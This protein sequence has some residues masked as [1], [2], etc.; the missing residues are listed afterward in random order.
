MA[1]WPKGI[2]PSGKG[3]RITVYHRGEI[4]YDKTHE[5][6]PNS[7]TDLAAAVRFREDL[8]QKLRLGLSIGPDDKHAKYRIFR[9]VAQGYL[10]SRSVD[11]CTAENYLRWLNR[12]W[13]PVFGH[14]AIEEI[15]RQE[16]EDRLAQIR[17]ATPTKRNI[18]SPLAGVFSYAGIHPNPAAG[19][20]LE[21]QT[22][23]RVERYTPAERDAVL[24]KLEGQ[25]KVYFAL[26]FG[27]GIRPGEALALQWTD[28]NGTALDIT[29]QRTRSLLKNYTKTKADRIVYVPEWV[30]DILN[31]HST[32]LAGGFLF[33]TVHGEP[34]LRASEFNKAWR[35]AHSKA[36][37]GAHPVKCRRPYVCR[38]TRASE[39]LSRGTPPAAA[40]AQLGHS[41][42]M[43]LEIYARFVEEFAKGDF[44]MYESAKPNNK[45]NKI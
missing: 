22:R 37:V 2:R 38:H 28:Y 4:A 43:F 30:R 9:D 17:L 5:G 29:K 36:R 15:T 13:L 11:I 42:P 44:S 45:A 40:A 32:R 3:I 10:E 39:M 27:T 6:N 35:D 25:D 33:L 7:R 23:G 24:S 19:I 12:H 18:L 1:N 16:I 26:L 14:R 20:A 21:R 8:R 31:A 34:F 41:V